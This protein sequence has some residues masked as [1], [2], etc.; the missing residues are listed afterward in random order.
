MSAL[1]VAGRYSSPSGP[2]EVVVVRD[3]NGRWQVVDRGATDVILVETL[4]GYDD[5][6]DQAV[7]V[8]RDYAEQQQAFRDGRREED[9]L[10]RQRSI[11]SSTTDAA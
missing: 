2:H 4:T 11:G 7:A 5:R 3:P 9:P 1:T 8:G 10:P 6:L